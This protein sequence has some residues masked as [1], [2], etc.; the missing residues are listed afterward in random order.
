M[1]YTLPRRQH[2]FGVRGVASFD[3]GQP[4]NRPRA[5]RNRRICSR[6]GLVPLAA[7]SVQDT[8]LYRPQVFGERRV[9]ILVT[10]AGSQA[11]QG[12][13]IPSTNNC[14]CGEHARHAIAPSADAFRARCCF[15]DVE[16]PPLKLRRRAVSL[17]S[18]GVPNTLP[19]RRH[20][21]GIFFPA[22][23]RT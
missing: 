21:A 18:M 4:L 12:L 16:Q 2:A 7:M 14:G 13:F 10:W 9:S 22:P 1:Q 17:T 3:E 6:P 8:L 15:V 19:R 11:A 23:P 5:S 20:G